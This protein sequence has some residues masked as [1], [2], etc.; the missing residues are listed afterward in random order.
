MCISSFRTSIANDVKIHLI[1][2]SQ[3]VKSKEYHSKN[4]TDLGNIGE[5]QR[6]NIKRIKPKEIY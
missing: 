6:L 1:L 2:L 3:G 4:L 5:N